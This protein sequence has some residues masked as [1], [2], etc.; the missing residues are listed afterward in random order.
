[1][2]PVLGR[3]VDRQPVHT[4]SSASPAAPGLCAA[5]LLRAFAGSGKGQL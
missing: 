3:E 2:F 4:P 5:L 1:M